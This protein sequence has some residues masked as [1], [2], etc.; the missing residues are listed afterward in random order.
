M[1][2]VPQDRIERR[3]ELLAL[4]LLLLLVSSFYVDV[5]FLGNNFFTRDLTHYHYPMKKVVRDTVLAGQL[6]VWNPMYAGGQPMAANPAYEVFYPPQ[7]LTLIPDYNLGFRLHIVFHVWLAA[8]GAFLFLRSRGVG[9]EVSFLGAA[10][11]VLGGPFA[12][13]FNLLPFM[14]SVAWVPWVALCAGRFFDSGSRRDFSLLVVALG[15]QAIICEPTTLLQTWFLLGLWGAC[16]GWERGATRRAVAAARGF[17][18]AVGAVVAAIFL[19]A[20]QFLPALDHAVDSVRRDGFPWQTVSQWSF[21]PLRLVEIIYPSFLGPLETGGSHYWG[22]SLYPDVGGPYFYSVYVGIPFVALVLAGLATRRRG[23]GFVL[24][25]LGVSVVLALGSWTPVLRVLYDVGL[26]PS[27]RYP[28]KFALMGAFVA[29][30]WGCMILDDLIRGNARAVRVTAIV[31]VT[32]SVVA[33][34]VTVWGFLPGYEEWFMSFWP[35]S[36]PQAA[37]VSRIHW[38]VAVGRGLAFAAAIE[39]ARRTRIRAAFA[40]LVLLLVADLGPLG[41]QINPRMPAR[42]FDAPPAAAE[43]GT[44]ASGSRL[45]HLAWL[46][47]DTVL[48]NKVSGGHDAYWALRN[49][50]IPSLPALWGVPTILEWDVD[51]THLLHTREL[52]NYS[53]AY[54]SDESKESPAWRDDAVRQIAGICNA[55]VVAAIREDAAPPAAWEDREAAQP[56]EF[57]EVRG[58]PRYYFATEAVSVRDGREMFEKL[59]ARSWPQGVAFVEG[60]ATPVSWGVVHRV[61]ERPNEIVM[62]VEALG[63]ATLV[64]SV[65]R[66]KYWS[67]TIDGNRVPIRSVNLAFQGVTVPPGRHVVAWRY[68][69][70]L[71]PA[72]FAVSLTMALGLLI[73][74]WKGRMR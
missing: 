21:P 42:Y 48:A 22:S 34:G 49:A 33:C 13:V 3:R 43:L 39:I 23:Y 57:R 69:N 24:V 27:I 29:I 14:F 55:G 58:G 46:D 32:S 11:F 66:H 4:G 17:S 64:A 68:W 44:M 74:V 59:V 37:Y 62:E 35:D 25:T 16:R 28:E 67:A 19:S 72:G 40:L 7:W 30:A 15:M 50:M 71:I 10:A 56:I 63:E 12:S 70:P 47:R 51:E 65:T 9:R 6:P 26:L 54:M 53:I 45:L 31:L 73:V 38:M 8:I 60:N 1:R 2:G 18:F 61:S 41:N 36:G 20:V 5:L 52:L